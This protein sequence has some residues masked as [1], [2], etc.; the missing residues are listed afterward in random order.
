MSLIG[1][2]TTFL[3]STGANA[4]RNLSQ[5]GPDAYFRIGDRDFKTAGDF[6]SA[7]ILSIRG[8]SHFNVSGDLTIT[9]GL[10][11]VTEQTGYNQEN[12]LNNYAGATEFGDA[13]V[14]VA[15]KLTLADPAMT[16]FDITPSA[17]TAQVH[18]AGSAS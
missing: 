9:G 8:N 11:N 6:T 10:F 2:N 18:V 7:G 17:H 16:R 13:V 3:D 15:G 1:P 12:T 14:S 5:T 4:L